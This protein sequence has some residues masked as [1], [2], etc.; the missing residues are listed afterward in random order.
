MKRIAFAILTVFCLVTPGRAQPDSLLAERINEFEHWLNTAIDGD[1]FV[2]ITVAL[3]VDG[4]HWSRGYGLADRENQVSATVESSYR[5]ASVSKSLTAVGVLKLVEMGKINLDDEV[6]V[7]V[8]DFPRKQWPVTIRHLLRHTSGISHYKDYEAEA[9]HTRQ[10]STEEALAVFEDW[11]LEFEPGTRMGYTTYGFN[12]LGAVIE[13]ATGRSFCEYM[14]EEV[15][16]PLGMM[17]TYCDNPDDAIPNRVEGYILRDG[18]IA[19]STIVNTSMKY[20]GGGMRSIASDMVR[21]AQG[22]SDGTILSKPWVDSMWMSGVTRDGHYTGY[23][24]GWSTT[25]FNGHFLTMHTGAQEETRT[26]LLYLPGANVTVVA[27]SNFEH[28][29]P[30]EA[31]MRLMAAV[32]AED[33]GT[34]EPYTGD[35]LD[36]IRYTTLRWCFDDGFSHYDRYRL[37]VTVAAQEVDAAFAYVNTL[38]GDDAGALGIDSLQTLLRE[39]RHP[40]A[41]R[42]FA[43]VGSSVAAM[44]KRNKG[45]RYIEAAHGRGV[46]AMYADYCALAAKTFNLERFDVDFEKTV[47]AWN[48]AW[49][50]SWNDDVRA[51]DFS[52]Q[53]NIDDA[54]LI[55]RRAVQNQPICPY[56]M[57]DIEDACFESMR[58]GKEEQALELAQMGVDLYPHDDVSNATMGIVRIVQDDVAE[59]RKYIAMA[60]DWDPD[61]AASAD[62]LNSMA[63]RLAG[64]KQ[65]DQAID[66]LAVAIEYYPDVANLYDSKA[67]M[68]LNKGDLAASRQ[69]Y[70]KAIEMDPRL[71]NPKQMLQRIDQMEAEQSAG[72]R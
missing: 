9:V 72:S 18:E 22:M 60:I 28:S 15:W 24:Y 17:E 31:A 55:M 66:V 13:G 52:S 10:M 4:Y 54:R 68:Y 6:Q 37:P 16:R 3:E 29:K 62:G 25:S 36:D 20:G 41:G 7:Y 51:L 59:G 26:A 39:G 32:L 56:L 42:P 38:L 14:T 65:Y 33:Y 63:Y 70:E 46:L 58:E 27:L 49:I 69:W 2:G 45:T 61:G 67:E 34:P 50:R 1:E 44:L 71:D 43:K 64:R 48:K 57:A 19:P 11:D 47:M 53:V 35:H 12:L 23:G 21:F 5:L 40:A 8:P 30:R